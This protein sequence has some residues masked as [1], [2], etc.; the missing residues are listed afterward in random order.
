MANNLS[1][2]TN[3][4]FYSGLWTDIQKICT[5]LKIGDGRL[6]NITQD[7]VAFYQE[8]VDR[9][10][11]DMVGQY[12]YTP[13]RPYNLYQPA[14]ATTISVFPGGI[15]EIARYWTAGQLMLAEFQQL[16]ENITE[17][18]NAMITDSKQKIYD[19]IKFSRRIPG[20]RLKHNLHFMPPSLGPGF[21]PEPNF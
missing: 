15:R 1:P 13:L 14:T 10:I 9:S 4:I 12:Y 16:S 7:L 20:Q 18:V 11:D 2:T 8:Q 17:Q 19:I 21:V 3:Q 6:A 5:V